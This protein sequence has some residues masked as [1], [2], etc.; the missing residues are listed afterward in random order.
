[1]ITSSAG[2]Q[3]YSYDYGTNYGGGGGLGIY[4]PTTIDNYVG[5]AS[6]CADVPKGAIP[7]SQMAHTAVDLSL[8]K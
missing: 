7:A 2:V 5:F 1:V 3:T 4:G 8:N 6:G